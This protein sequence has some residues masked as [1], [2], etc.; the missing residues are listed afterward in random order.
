MS[1]KICPACQEILKEEISYCPNCG[2]KDLSQIFLSSQDRANWIK[3]TLLPFID[4]MMPRIFLNQEHVIFII[5]SSKLYEMGKNF[6]KLWIKTPTI[7]ADDVVSADIGKNYIIWI[8]NKENINLKG[9]DNYSGTFEFSPFSKKVLADPQENIF[10]I[11]DDTEIV[12]AFGIE[13]DKF[14]IYGEEIYIKDNFKLIK[15]SFVVSNIPIPITNILY[16]NYENDMIFRDIMKFQENIDS[17]IHS[18]YIDNGG[19]IAVFVKKNFEIVLVNLKS[20]EK[21]FIKYGDLKKAIES[22]DKN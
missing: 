9:K 20:K 1:Q 8:D 18:M 12:Y 11:I 7:I 5:D 3:N 10:W 16:S 13:L 21:F 22:S 2:L 6:D 14:K 4:T 17:D 19:S 15:T